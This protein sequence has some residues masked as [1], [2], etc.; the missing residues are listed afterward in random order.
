MEPYK[1]VMRFGDDVAENY[2]ELA[3]REDEVETVA[4]MA[5]LA[6]GGPALELAIGTGRIALPL[7]ALCM[8]F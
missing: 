3:R 8:A 6:R 1:P 7:A 4:F 5:Q 2:D